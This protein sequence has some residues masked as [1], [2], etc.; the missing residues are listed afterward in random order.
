M[1]LRVNKPALMLAMGVL[2]L[3]LAGIGCGDD[4]GAAGTSGTSGSGG[5][6]GTGGGTPTIAEC[7]ADADAVLASILPLS[8]ECLTCICTA[9]VELTTACTETEQCWPLVNCSVVMCQGDQTC[10]V[11]MCGAFLGGYTA[12]TEL[13]PAITG[14]QS[15]CFPQTN[16]DGGD[17]DGGN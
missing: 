3:A 10:S 7:V 2:V 14:C 11:N 9:D 5:T 8:D 12:A 15:T 17:T 13:R 16:I 1:D 4:D 6:G